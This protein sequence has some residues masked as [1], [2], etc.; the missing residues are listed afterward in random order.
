MQEC[1]TYLLERGRWIAKRYLIKY[2][3]WGSERLKFQGRSGKRMMT[4]RRRHVRDNLDIW[5][6]GSG[7]TFGCF[8]WVGGIITSWF[9]QFRHFLAAQQITSHAAVEIGNQHWDQTQLFHHFYAFVHKCCK[10]SRKDWK[11]RRNWRIFEVT[12][13]W[14]ERRRWE[15]PKTCKKNLT[16]QTGSSMHSQLQL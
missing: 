10:S 3:F 15:D 12:S 1:Q 9:E 11:H 13:S 2:L 6:G 5:T 14:Q 8:L 7:R 16:I 4:K